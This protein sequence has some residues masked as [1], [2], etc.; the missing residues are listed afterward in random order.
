MAPWAVLLGA[1][2]AAAYT[3]HYDPKD[4][5]FNIVVPPNRG[6]AFA[7][8]VADFGLAVSATTGKCCQQDV[9]DL[10]REKR[11]QLEAQGKS[12]LFVGAAGDNFYWTGAKAQA[13]GGAEQWARWA[14]VYS[15][16]TDVPWLAAL[17]NHDLGDGDLYATCPWQAPRVTIDGQA[18]AANQLDADKGGY[19]PSGSENFHL[20]DFNYKY[21][22]DALN[23]EIYGL[24]QNCVDPHGIGGD[25]D[26]RR[27]LNAVCGPLNL[28]QRLDDVALSGEAMLMAGASEGAF[29]AT[30]KRNV[31][32]L[33]HY[34]G[35][36]GALEALFSAYSP[37]DEDFDFRCS[38][39]HTH[40]TL[41]ES[42][43]DDDCRYSQNGG[44]GGC[45]D[46]D[47][48]DDNAGFAILHFLEEGGMRLELQKLG[49]NCTFYPPTAT[50]AEHRGRATPLQAA[51]ANPVDYL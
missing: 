44:G 17:G 38:F 27:K 16:L 49:R 25:D 15:G 37:E 33:Q 28:Q 18:Y 14:A 7:L 11:A 4:N 39:G 23:L 8:L 13:E 30:Q 24:D 43:P 46:D 48:V 26:G 3:N 29:D 45:C 22:I 51:D 34:P 10:M 35:R 47:V 2:Q 32:I 31:L 20:P 6:N 9:A 40:A 12:L 19:R 36:C 41:C 1:A 42:G 5:A 50:L 21:T